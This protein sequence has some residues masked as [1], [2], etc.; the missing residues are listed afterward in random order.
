MPPLDLPE[1]N[2]ILPSLIS[3]PP[4]EALSPAELTELFYNAPTAELAA[5]AGERTRAVHGR[6]ILLRGLLEYTNYCSSNC[7]YCGIRREN[8]DVIRYRI[9]EKELLEAA[10]AGFERGLR[11]F[12]I[13]GGEDSLYPVSRICALVESIKEMS[14]G[15][16]A[17]TLSCGMRSPAQYKAF[18]RAGADRYLLRFETSDPE[19]HRYLR[20]GKTLDTRLKAL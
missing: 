17:V 19:L 7:L 20:D 12:V 13:Q 6:D 3:R 16:A 10:A 1:L 18:R 2:K 11:T 8:R 4:A 15:E 9:E 5:L 14:G